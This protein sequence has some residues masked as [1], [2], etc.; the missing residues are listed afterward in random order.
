M[1][2]AGGGVTTG[3]GGT[4]GG[5]SQSSNAF[6][7]MNNT[8]LRPG[9]RRRRIPLLNTSWVT[10]LQHGKGRAMRKD[11]SGLVDTLYD[12]VAGIVA[13]AAPDTND[14]LQKSFTEFGDALE[15]QLEVEYG[16][17]PEPLAKG[18][19]HVSAFANALVK[20]EAS[21]EAIKAGTRFTGRQRT[22][23]RLDGGGAL[24]R[25]LGHGLCCSSNGQR[26]RSQCRR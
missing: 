20:M 3:A 7:G 13:S 22:G 19:N 10:R 15:Q 24:D 9:R 18:L 14:L 1:S 11:V 8:D 26:H 6:G 23:G 21:I 4:G 16:P 5:F 2:G 12:S 25:F 17:D